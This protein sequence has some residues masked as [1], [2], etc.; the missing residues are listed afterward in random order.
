MS[1]AVSCDCYFF[2]FLFL[3][4]YCCCF[5]LGLLFVVVVTQKD[6]AD[7]WFVS[8]FEGGTDIKNDELSRDSRELIVATGK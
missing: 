5:F 2:L 3:F 1:P 4:L 8:V 7:Y 6:Y